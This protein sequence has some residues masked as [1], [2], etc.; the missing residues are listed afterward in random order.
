MVGGCYIIIHGVVGELLQEDFYS[1]EGNL[2]I[3]P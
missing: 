2:S 3:H 1:A